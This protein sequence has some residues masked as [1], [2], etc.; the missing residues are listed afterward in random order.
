MDVS[1]LKAHLGEDLFGQVETALKDVDGLTIIPT[2]DGSW[3][4]KAKFDEE[5]GKQKTLKATITTLNQQLAEAKQKGESATALQATIDTLKQQVADKDATITGMK[6]SGKIREALTKAKVRDAAVV[7]KLLDATKIGEDDKG[8][9]TGLDDQIKAL[10]ESSAYLFAE[11][12]GSGHR[13]GGGGGKDPQGGSGGS[14]GS[15]GNSNSEINSIIRAAAGRS[16]E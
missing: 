11:D 15:G 8:N 13:G 14:G 2:N 9:L 1:T 7:E 5:T 16:V 12:G 6:R 3:I 10:K 4:P